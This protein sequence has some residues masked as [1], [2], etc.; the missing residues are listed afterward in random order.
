MVDSL[1]FGFGKGELSISQKQG[2]I[3]LIPKKDK[4]LSYLKN[5]RPISLLNVD[6]KIATKTLALRLGKVLPKIIDKAQTSY[7]KGRFIRENIRLISDILDYTAD[8]NIGGI[9][10]FIDFE[11]AFDSLEWDFLHKA[12]ETFNFGNDFR[13]WVKVLYNDTSSC[14]INNGFASDA[15]ELKRGVRQGCPLSGLL[16][17][18]AVELLSSAIRSSKEIKGIQ[19]MEKEIKL[20]QYADDTTTFCADVN[21]LHILLELLDLFKYCSGLKLNSTK[22]E[23]L[24]LG[25]DASRKDEFD[26]V[27]W[28]QRPISALGVSF[29][30]ETMRCEKENFDKKINNIQNSLNLWSQRDLSLYGRIT[31]AKTLKRETLGLSKYLQAAVYTRPSMSQLLSIKWFMISSG[32]INLPKLRETR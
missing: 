11:K 12:L 22:C 31:I 13:A 7:L 19:V 21:A 17:I 23:A 15:F 18:I 3:R 4:N 8:K 9:A 16:F 32:T 26:G 2:I 10:L 29:S 5:W 24:W 6:Y 27:Q 1:N 20:S 30:Y 28:P 14:T 25:K